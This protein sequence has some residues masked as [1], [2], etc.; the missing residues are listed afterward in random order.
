MERSRESEA[1]RH[2]LGSADPR[3]ALRTS[4]RQ[5]LG[6]HVLSK[7]ALIGVLDSLADE[8]RTNRDPQTVAVIVEALDV[9]EGQA[10]PHAIASYLD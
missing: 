4:V 8:Y 10:S 5:I 6:S 7:T 3:V 9:L 2:A 1:V